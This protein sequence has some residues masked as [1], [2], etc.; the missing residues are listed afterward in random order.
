[1]QL[2]AIRSGETAYAS[3]SF[4]LVVFPVFFFVFQVK[5]IILFFF[6]VFQVTKII[7]FFFVFRESCASFRTMPFH[8]FTLVFLCIPIR[9]CWAW[10]LR[11]AFCVM[12]IVGWA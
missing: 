11:F 10:A 3:E 12:G 7:L 5:K 9:V 2:N 8:P 6:S 4:L 1:M